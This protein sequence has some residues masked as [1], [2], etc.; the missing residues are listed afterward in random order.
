MVIERK[1]KWYDHI[2]RSNTMVKTILKGTIKGRQGVV[3]PMTR[4]QDT[5]V[6]WSRNEQRIASTIYMLMIFNYL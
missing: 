5:I 2:T 1:L 3:R 6:E 4:W